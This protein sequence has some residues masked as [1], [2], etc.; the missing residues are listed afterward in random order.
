[1]LFVADFIAIA[2]NAKLLL[3]TRVE[4]PGVMQRNISAKLPF[5]SHKILNVKLQSVMGCILGFFPPMPGHVFFRMFF[6]IL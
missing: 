5:C 3:D 2:L 4:N 1:M 6:F